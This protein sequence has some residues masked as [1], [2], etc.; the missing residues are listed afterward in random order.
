MGEIILIIGVTLIC[1]VG[2]FTY[3]V[4]EHDI[5]KK[6][7]SKMSDD[8]ILK[9]FKDY[10]DLP[11]EDDFYCHDECI[12]NACEDY[13]KQKCKVQCDKCKPINQ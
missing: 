9:Y 11:I 12:G 2:M 7:I 13:D 10:Y 4:V 6:R 1:C 8:E 5:T 3:I